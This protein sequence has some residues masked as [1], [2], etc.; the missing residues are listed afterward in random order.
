MQIKDKY[1]FIEDDETKLP[2]RPTKNKV[3]TLG[4][5][6]TKPG[7]L[8]N[9]RIAGIRFDR[10]YFTD[11]IAIDI[12]KRSGP[13]IDQ[14]IEVKKRVTKMENIKYI[15]VPKGTELT[16]KELKRIIKGEK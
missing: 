12:F 15:P 5:Y 11:K 6:M 16:A 7:Y 2:T 10:Y 8:E 3:D 1:G 9:H 14:E 13:E 4:R